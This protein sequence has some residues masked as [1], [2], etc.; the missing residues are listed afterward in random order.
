MMNCHAST[1]I[2]KLVLSSL[3]DILFRYHYDFIGIES[4]SLVFQQDS[5][6]HQ[7][8]M[9]LWHVGQIMIDGGRAAANNIENVL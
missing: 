1:P 9:E 6:Q 7:S 2:K 5:K 3:K 4:W 8:R